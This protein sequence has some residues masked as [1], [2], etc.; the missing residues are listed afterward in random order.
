MAKKWL[1]LKHE[2][3]LHQIQTNFEIQLHFNMK[4]ICARNNLCTQKISTIKMKK[5]NT[6]ENQM[7]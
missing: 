3:D 6:N 1:R 7:F 2:D 5:N 4:M